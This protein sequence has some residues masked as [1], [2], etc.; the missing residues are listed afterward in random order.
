MINLESKLVPLT[1][2]DL[3]HLIDALDFMME[4]GFLCNGELDALWVYLYNHLA[5]VT[6]DSTS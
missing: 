5:G 1:D 3:R 2:R 6:D 4:Q